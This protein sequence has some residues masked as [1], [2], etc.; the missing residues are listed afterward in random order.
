M[1]GYQ[2]RS[3]FVPFS[4]SLAILTA[5]PATHGLQTIGA[6]APA[7]PEVPA[8]LEIALSGYDLLTYR[9]GTAPQPGR[10]EIFHDHNGYRYLFVS[11]ANRDSFA[12][13]PAFL[14]PQFGHACAFALGGGH[15]MAAD[16]DL[17]VIESDSLFL[18]S[19]AEKRQ[20]WLE[21]PVRRRKLAEQKW[22]DLG[23]SI[24]NFS[25]KLNDGN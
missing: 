19:S 20:S 7:A 16:P 9:D 14:A 6:P 4:L 10:P 3:L 11:E 22:S 21:D 23:N 15:T 12:S 8:G 17:F 1:I 18:F 2:T 25:I 5:G 13:N 24:T